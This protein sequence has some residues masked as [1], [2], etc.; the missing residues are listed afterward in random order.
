MNG[1][2]RS[3][4]AGRPLAPPR[5]KH[6]MPA[7]AGT[8]NRRESALLEGLDQDRLNLLAECLFTLNQR[9][10]GP[11]AGAYVVVAVASGRWCVGQLS[12]DRARPVILF[13]DLEFDDCSAAQKTA[14]RLQR[15]PPGGADGARQSAPRQP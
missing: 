4:S 1:G 13:E 11:V 14:R 2:N 6:H 10:F 9:R 15:R 12:A 7:L 3:V 5:G 8:P